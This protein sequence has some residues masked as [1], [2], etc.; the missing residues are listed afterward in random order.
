[1]GAGFVVLNIGGASE[2]FPCSSFQATSR[3]YVV[4]AYDVTVSLYGDPAIFGNSTTLLDTITTPGEVLAPGANDFGVADFYVNSFVLSW[5]ISRGGIGTTCQNVGASRVELDVT[6]AGQSTPTQYFFNCDN[7]SLGAGGLYTSATMAIPYANPPYSVSWQA[8]LL[9]AA[10]QD[11]TPGTA[12]QYFNVTASV[13]AD[14]G[15]VAFAL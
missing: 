4:G 11:L 15:S 7:T 10:G 8:F 1:V 14:L 2:T 12:T 13:Q 9:N 3:A 5:T 6:F